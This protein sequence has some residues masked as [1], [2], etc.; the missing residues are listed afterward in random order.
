MLYF[1]VVIISN[2]KISVD[3][4]PRN[5]LGDEY[6]Q[7]MVDDLFL[8]DLSWYFSGDEINTSTGS[9]YYSSL[10][11]RWD[12]LGR[13][14]VCWDRLGGPNQLSGTYCLELLVV[15]I[16]LIF[17]FVETSMPVRQ[18]SVYD[19]WCM[20]IGVCRGWIKLVTRS[21][22]Q[23]SSWVTAVVWIN[24]FVFLGDNMVK[25]AAIIFNHCKSE[26]LPIPSGSSVKLWLLFERG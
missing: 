5:S 17:F 12:K 25:S 13:G 19:N 15:W 20:T 14:L 10:S 7:W 24:L 21:N 16:N 23:V 8:F 1:R 3:W 4:Q 18:P 22:Y 26:A 9:V 6:R 2:I 11:Y